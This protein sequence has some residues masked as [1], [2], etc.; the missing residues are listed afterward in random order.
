M[1]D[2]QAER[3]A[4]DDGVNRHVLLVSQIGPARKARAI[5]FTMAVRGLGA[6]RTAALAAGSGGCRRVHVRQGI[7]PT[8]T[9]CSFAASDLQNQP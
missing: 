1:F 7:T 5:P 4:R 3:N 6:L 8:I 2:Y 9:A